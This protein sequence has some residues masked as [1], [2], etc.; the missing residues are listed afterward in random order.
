MMK[1]PGASATLQRANATNKPILESALVEQDQHY[2]CLCRGIEGEIE[3]PNRSRKWWSG[4]ESI[5]HLLGEGSTA[6]TVIWETYARQP[7]RV[8]LLKPS[9]Q[10]HVA[11]VELE[12]AE[13]N[14]AAT[15]PVRGPHGQK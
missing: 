2:W 11:R 10:E 7:E 6:A 3:K 9:L 15:L 5:S 8:V 12:Q 1:L 14:L 4:P 13:K